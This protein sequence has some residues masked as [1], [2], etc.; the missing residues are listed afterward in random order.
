MCADCGGSPLA[1]PLSHD[2]LWCYMLK[3][4]SMALWAWRSLYAFVSLWKQHYT[5]NSIYIGIKRILGSLGGLSS[6]LVQPGLSSSRHG[7]DL[8]LLLESL[9]SLCWKE[10]GDSLELQMASASKTAKW[11]LWFHWTQNQIFIF[12]FFIETFCVPHALGAKTKSYFGSPLYL[13]KLRH[14]KYPPLLS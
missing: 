9:F 5:Y 2:P 8:C 3:A 10:V 7:I 11:K 13:A 14:C 1:G 4:F 12:F 6:D